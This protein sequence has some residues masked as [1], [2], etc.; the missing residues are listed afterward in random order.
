[1]RVHACFQLETR[2]KSEHCYGC[3]LMSRRQDALPRRILVED[4]KFITFQVFTQCF[5]G[6]ICEKKKKKRFQKHS[7]QHARSESRGKNLTN[8]R[9]VVK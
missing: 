6:W 1:M 2:I 8:K 4:K 9:K 3:A 5:H 7:I